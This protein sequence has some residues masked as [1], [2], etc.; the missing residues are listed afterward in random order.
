MFVRIVSSH[1]LLVFKN[2]SL[3]LEAVKSFFRLKPL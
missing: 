3:S 1:L 2:L